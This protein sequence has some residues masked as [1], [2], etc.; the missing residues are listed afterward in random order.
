M[1]GGRAVRR[2]R[3]DAA[4]VPHAAVGGLHALLRQVRGRIIEE[5]NYA[6]A[7]RPKIS[8]KL[9][10]ASCV[11]YSDCAYY[12]VYVLVKDIGRRLPLELACYRVNRVMLINLCTATIK[13]VFEGDKI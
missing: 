5:I 3:G 2:Q 1:T 9:I 13:P 12:W 11:C 6:P 8:S 4:A 7:V 10:F